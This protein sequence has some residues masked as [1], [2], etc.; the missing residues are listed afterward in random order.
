MEINGHNVYWGVFSTVGHSVG[1]REK[2]NWD[3]ISR[4]AELPIGGISQ[5]GISL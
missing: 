4:E 2:L 1:Q 3:T 5:A